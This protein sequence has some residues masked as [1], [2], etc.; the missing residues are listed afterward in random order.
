MNHRYNKPYVTVRYLNIHRIPGSSHTKSTSITRCGICSRAQC[1]CVSLAKEPR[2]LLWRSV[3][4]GSR[5][6]F[7][8]FSDVCHIFCH[9][10][11]IY[12]YFFSISKTS[13][14]MLNMFRWMSNFVSCTSIWNIGHEPLN[15]HHLTWLENPRAEIR[16]V[17]TH[18]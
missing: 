7:H 18:L 13:I 11:R 15:F 16:R 17:S 3:L 14:G 12:F 5:A 1:C 10:S 6:V 2:W 9:V 4:G 8:G